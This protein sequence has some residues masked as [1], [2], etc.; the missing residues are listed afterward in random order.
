MPLAGM[1]LVRSLGSVLLLLF[2]L[3]SYKMSGV[4]S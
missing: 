3:G 4:N 2:R 1:V